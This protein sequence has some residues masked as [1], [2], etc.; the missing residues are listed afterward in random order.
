MSDYYVA[1]ARGKTLLIRNKLTFEMG[2]G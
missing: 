1:G 2:I